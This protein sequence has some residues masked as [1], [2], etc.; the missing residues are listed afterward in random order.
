[1]SAEIQTCPECGGAARRRPFYSEFFLHVVGGTIPPSGTQDRNEYD[2]KALKRRGW[3]Y[4]RSVEHIRSHLV[5]T[6]QGK[7][8]DV[9]AANADV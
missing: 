6:E 3:D 5:E 7:V 2:K 4:E 1:M 9:A 8:L